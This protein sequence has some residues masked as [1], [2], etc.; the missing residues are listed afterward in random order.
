VAELDSDILGHVPDSRPRLPAPGP[1]FLREIELRPGDTR[2]VGMSSPQTL[3]DGWWV[4]L[5]WCDQDGLLL[6]FDDLAPL[7]GTPPGSPLLRLGPGLSGTLSGLVLEEGGRQ[8][9]R[10]RLGRPAEDEDAPWAAPLVVLVGF[11]F[12]PA[13]VLTMRGSELAQT[14]LR[15]FRDALARLSY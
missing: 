15:A 7:S 9:L 12:E 4:A 6:S 3:D 2:S 5:L 11:R 8:Q 14:V 10:L 1:S 13:R